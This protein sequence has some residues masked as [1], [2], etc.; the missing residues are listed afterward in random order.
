MFDIDMK[1]RKGI[2][3]TRLK[4]YLNGDTASLLESNLNNTIKTNGI[5]YVLLNLNKLEYIDKYGVETISDTYKEII[6][7]KGKLIIC[8]MDKLLNNEYYFT[9]N[10]YGVSE[11]ELAYDI[12]SI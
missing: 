2:L 7:N 8:G 11:E 10:L 4:G 9:N 12:V 3:I 1:F 6:N 5:K